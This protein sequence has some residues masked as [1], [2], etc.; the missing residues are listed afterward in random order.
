MKI[1]EPLY[2]KPLTSFYIFET[3][4]ERPSIDCYEVRQVH[5]PTVVLDRELDQNVQADGIVS[6]CLSKP[7]AIKTADCLPVAVIGKDG[8]ALVHV[9]WRN[10]A[11]KIIAHPLIDKLS[12]Q[13]FFIGPHISEKCFE[14]GDEFQGHFP[15]SKHFSLAKEKMV[16]SLYNELKDQIISLFPQAAVSESGLCTYGH[17]KL[18]SFRRDGTSKR[19]W[20]LL[21]PCA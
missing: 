8:V 2:R 6:R 4:L 9:G 14:V 17:Q 19:N 7:L 10:L 11:G 5:G 1:L 3:Y 20:N 12:P 13:S 16:F 15:S 21:L 18:H